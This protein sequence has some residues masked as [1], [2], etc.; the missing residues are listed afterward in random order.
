MLAKHEKPLPPNMMAASAS[1]WVIEASER[2]DGGK[3]GIGVVLLP[4]DD[5]I[6]EKLWIHRLAGTIANELTGV[7]VKFKNLTPPETPGEFTLS[8]DGTRYSAP[9]W[10]HQ[11]AGMYVMQEALSHIIDLVEETRV[12]TGNPQY[13]PSG[14]ELWWALCQSLKMWK[15]DKSD[16]ENYARVYFGIGLEKIGLEQDLILNPQFVAIMEHAYQQWVTFAVQEGN[17]EKFLTVLRSL[18][19]IR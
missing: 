9:A 15:F 5:G 2:K 1:V 4:P 3:K 12:A 10:M 7:I 16:P 13:M 8:N 6:P 17:K 19:T 11:M 18:G 14:D